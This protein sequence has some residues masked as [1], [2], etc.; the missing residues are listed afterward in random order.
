MLGIDTFD[1]HLKAIDADPLDGTW[2]QAWQLAGSEE[3]STVL[4]QRAADLLDLNVIATGPST[5]IGLGPDFKPHAALGWSLQALKGFPGIGSD[6]IEAGLASPSIQN[7]NGAMNALEEWGPDRW[8]AGH[9]AKLERLA[10]I[11]PHEKAKERARELLH[12][13]YEGDR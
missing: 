2:F 13:R 4:A 8:T 10:S 12:Q 1:R 9:I 7:R 11:D 5:A 6:L 3:R